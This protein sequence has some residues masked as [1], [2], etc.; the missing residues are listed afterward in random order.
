MTDDRND[1]LEPETIDTGDEGADAPDWE[2]L[3]L[4]ARQ[5]VEQLRD[6]YLRSV[7]ELDNYRKRVARD[8][9]QQYLRSRMELIRQLLP[10]T[11][12]FGLAMSHVPEDYLGLPWLEGITLIHRK[13]ETYLSGAGV[14]PIEAIGRPFDPNYH[15]A[16]MRETSDQYSEGVVTAEVRKGYMM[17]DEVLRPT[18]VKVSMGPAQE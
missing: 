15:E 16:L 2:Q 8:R 4:D 7:A 5:E 10:A 17:G 14:T 3:L 6:K 13:L 1:I 11:D 9:E 18:L 12:D